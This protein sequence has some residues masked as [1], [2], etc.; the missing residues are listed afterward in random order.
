M[1]THFD[2]HKAAQTAHYFISR[3]G[4]EMEILKLVKLIYLADRHSLQKRRI[5]VVGGSYFSL[6][7]GPV[8]SEVLDLINDG[9][10]DENSPWELLISDRAQHRVATTNSLAEYDALS[11]SEQQ[12]LEEVWQQF[13][14]QGKWDLVEWTHRHCEEWS[15]PRGGRIEISARRL[16]ES[17]AWPRAEVDDFEAELA[18]QNRLQEILN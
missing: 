2:I 1:K 14:A 11:A 17:F 3:A 8:T 15:D 6:K 5:P 4:G 7:H 9:T 10:R 12:M 13:G 16:A 18:A